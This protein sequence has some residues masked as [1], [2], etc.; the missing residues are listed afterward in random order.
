VLANVFFIKTFDP[1]SGRDS[2]LLLGDGSSRLHLDE[3]SGSHVQNSFPPNSSCRA[4]V[5]R[6]G[7]ALPLKTNRLLLRRRRSQLAPA[8]VRRSVDKG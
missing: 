2:F 4:D 3:Y 5:H 6:S 1:V 8:V 7:L